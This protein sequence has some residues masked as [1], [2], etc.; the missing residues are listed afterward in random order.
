M[1]KMIAAIVDQVNVAG[2]AGGRMLQLFSE[3]TETQAQ[4]AVLAAKKLIEVDK[5]EVMLGV[6]G[7]S[8]SLA[9]IP[10]TNAAGM[11]LMNMS[12]APALS[13]PPANAKGLS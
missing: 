10:M 13:V 7:S 8:E 2:R 6:W 4:S 5:V 12:G 1:Q 9:V 11:I 3:D